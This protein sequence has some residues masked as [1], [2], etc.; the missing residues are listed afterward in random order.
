MAS[1]S[2]VKMQVRNRS[3]LTSQTFNSSWLKM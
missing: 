3:K 2:R 1:D